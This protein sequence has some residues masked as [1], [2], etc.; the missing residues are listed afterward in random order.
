MPPAKPLLTWPDLTYDKK[1]VNYNFSITTK[2]QAKQT[3]IDYN[4]AS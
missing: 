2:H 3:H 4:L 1:L